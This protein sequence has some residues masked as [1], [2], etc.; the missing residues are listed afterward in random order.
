MKSP[1]TIFVVSPTEYGGQIEHAYDTAVG[2]SMRSTADH[3]VLLTRPGAKEYLQDPT[4]G[5]VQI[6]EIFPPRRMKGHMLWNAVRPLFQIVDLLAEHIAIRNQMPKHHHDVLLVLDTSRYPYPRV[7]LRKRTRAKIVLFVHNARPHVTELRRSLR[8]RVLLYLERSSING[9]DLA[10]MHGKQ[11]LA[12][13]SSYTKTR[14]AAVPLPKTSFLDACIEDNSAHTVAHSYSLCIGELRENKGVEVAMDAAT[15]AR[16]GLVVAGKS[17][18]EAVSRRLIELAAQYEGIQLIDEFLDKNRFETLI[19]GAHVV[20]LPYT[21]F[22]AQSGILAKAMK[23]GKQIIASDLPALREQA[24][25]YRRISFVPPNDA[26]KLADRLQ[27]MM[28]SDIADSALQNENPEQEWKA[29]A[30][31][32]LTNA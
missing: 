6:R 5:G 10:V 17:H 30:N 28:A 26:E 15:K 1:N 16:V 14:L 13:V 2:L 9:V 12:T 32:L 29:V 8:D 24:V 31:V 11:Q 25:G 21:H 20:L 3:V 7:L 4:L 18:E 27:A 22:D 23:A 19:L